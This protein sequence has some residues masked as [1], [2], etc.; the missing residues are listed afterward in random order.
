VLIDNKILDTVTI[1]SNDGEI[2]TSDSR[3][4]GHDIEVRNDTGIGI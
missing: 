2:G 3:R 4:S 1:E